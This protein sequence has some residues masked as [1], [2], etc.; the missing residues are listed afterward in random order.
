MVAT[1]RH[2][3]RLMNEDDS[4]PGASLLDDVSALRALL[5]A[6]VDSSDDA[7]VAKDVHGT[8]LSWNHSAERIFGYRSDEAVGRSIYLVI[9]AD[10]HDEEERI[11]ATLRRGERIDHFETQR[12]R[13]DGSSIDVSVSISPIHD[14]TGAIVGIAKIARDITIARQAQTLEATLA[15][16]V[17]SSDDAIIGK[18][19]EG[20]VMAWNA[21][22]SRMFGYEAD[23]IVG[24]SILTLLPP[25]RHPE[26]AT[27]LAT[28]KRGD[29]IEHFE[30]E[31]VHKNGHRIA[32][33]LSV[34]PIKDA[35]GRI[36]GAAKIARDITR[37]R[38]LER[39]R[40]DLLGRERTA[41]GEA[42]AAN[43][44]KDAFLA[45]VSH[46]LR[47]PLSPIIAWA[48]MLRDGIL[49][50]DKTTK[51]I[52]TIERSASALAQLIDDLLDVS[53]I[54][55]GKMRIE[56]RPTDLS[57]VIHSAIEVIRP[58][59]DAKDIR[60]VSTIDSETGV[61]MGDPD[62]LVQ[63]VWNLLSNAVKFTPQGGRVHVVLE[64]VSSHVEITVSDT[65]QGFASEFR[66]YLF[67]R[68]R[69]A[70]GSATRHHGGL[71]LGLAIVRHI[72]ELHGGTVH[73]ESAGEHAGS[74]FTITLPRGIFQRS[75]REVERRH[76]TAPAREAAAA[77]GVPRPVETTLL[78]GLRMLVV[79][80][81]PDSNEV[82]STILAVRGAE[83]R[84][85]ASADGAVDVMRSWVPDLVVSDIG[86][87]DRDGFR[88]LTTIRATPALAD[89]PVIALTAYATRDDRIRI[90][91]AGFKLHLTK[92]VDPDELVA[93]VLNVTARVRQG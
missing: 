40:E 87:P 18:T 43:R 68:F 92:P 52:A 33:S 79:D 78:A 80:D 84:V 6:L 2:R 73:A 37:W 56:V 8:I 74:T 27:I 29:R 17:A 58:A 7:I 42:E 32:V 22:A 4:L 19:L 86:M 62:R 49:G 77:P 21:S 24:K 11:L 25:E 61:V 30:T 64:R 57:A 48:R 1:F 71:G 85:A 39:E 88:L 69:Q 59:A 16:I 28:L 35:S 70:D 13:K 26:E 55:A 41:R 12:I 23:E 93:G 9:P 91:T 81:E 45:T 76:P 89:V 66:P 47:T 38:A 83:V 10:R 90:L 60:L 31:R 72:V 51:A 34:S 36:V 46:E 63:V 53:R 3:T 14:C 75:A 82:V 65:G 20:V 54:I 15:A 67:E 44:A 5:A 50:A